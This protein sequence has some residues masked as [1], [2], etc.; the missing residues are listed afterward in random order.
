MAN[1]LLKTMSEVMK[2]MKRL[3]R[4]KSGYASQNMAC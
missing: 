2:T 3:F 4:R 1:L